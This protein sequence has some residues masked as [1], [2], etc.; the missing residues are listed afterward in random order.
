VGTVRYLDTA[1]RL[2]LVA[3]DLHFANGIALAPDGR[4]LFA[5][6]SEAA[7]VIQFDVATDGS[8]SGRRLFV[9]MTALGEAFDAFPDGIKLGPDGNYYIGLLSSGRIVV[10]DGA[11]RFMRKIEVP[12]AAAPNLTFS[13]DGKIIYVAAI[14]APHTPPYRGRVLA[15]DNA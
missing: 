12:A 8:L 2:R 4:S 15:I 6:E 14:D 7:R 10:V 3:D 9:R 5:V 11:G 1:G 13:P